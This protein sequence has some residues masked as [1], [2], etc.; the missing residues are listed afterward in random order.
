MGSMLN[1]IVDFVYFYYVA[2][3]IPHIFL[4]MLHAKNTSYFLFELISTSYWLPLAFH[5]KYVIERA[6]TK[7]VNTLF[8]KKKLNTDFSFF[9]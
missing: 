6:K 1:R 7:L 9:F 2:C 3:Q 8:Y 5:I 4:I